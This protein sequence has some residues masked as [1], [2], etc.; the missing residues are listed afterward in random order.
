MPV[1]VEWS[2]IILCIRWIR[3]VTHEDDLDKAQC[4][5]CLWLKSRW[6]RSEICEYDEMNFLFVCIWVQRKRWHEVCFCM[7]VYAAECSSM[8]FISVCMQVRRN[9]AAWNLFLCAC[10]CGEMR[11]NANH[12]CVY[13]NAANTTKFWWMRISLS[14]A[15][16]SIPTEAYCAE[17]SGNSAIF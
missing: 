7:H 4:I 16:W 13:A 17:Y 3:R 11:Q 12:L 1:A 10:K 9:A 15:T 2:S 5:H 14:S 6:N 8:K